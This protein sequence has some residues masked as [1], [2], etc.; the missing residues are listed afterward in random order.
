MERTAGRCRRGRGSTLRD[1][2]ALRSDEGEVRPPQVCA[3]LLL[4]PPPSP[5]ASAST[6]RLKASRPGLWERGAPAQHRR[7]RRGPLGRRGQGRREPE[8]ADRGG[9][10]QA[11]GR[12]AERPGAA[13]HPGGSDC[14]S[15]QAGPQP[16]RQR[17]RRRTLYF[18][19]T[20]L[21]TPC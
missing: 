1:P 15:G 19:Q 7:R 12:H 5:P 18:S 14:Q 17:Q 3:R 20:V 8:R 13:S 2:A 10:G 6:F 16:L 21:S 11:A 4:Q 9:L